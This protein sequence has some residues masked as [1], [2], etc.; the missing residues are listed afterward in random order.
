M[1]LNELRA[2]VL[3]L[4]DAQRTCLFELWC[5][6]LT[7]DECKAL[8]R[9]RYYTIPADF[10]KYKHQT[11]LLVY[12]FDDVACQIAKQVLLLSGMHEV[13]IASR[14]GVYDAAAVSCEYIQNLC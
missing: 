4:T 13:A 9:E 11:F 2:S 3:N 5:E 10:D 7:D 14:N 6:K 12:V 1:T 8:K